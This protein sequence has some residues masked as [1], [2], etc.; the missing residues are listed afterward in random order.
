MCTWF[1]MNDIGIS[2]IAA[3]ITA[4]G[5][6]SIE[7]HSIFQKH[8]ILGHFFFFLGALAGFVCLVGILSTKY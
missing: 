6:I 5:T 7:F 2:M 3:T 4:T 1:C 8:N